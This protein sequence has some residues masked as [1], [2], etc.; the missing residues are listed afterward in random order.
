MATLI[1]MGERL[2]DLFCMESDS[3]SVVGFSIRGGLAV[4]FQVFK[5]RHQICLW[6]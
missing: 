5:E 1:C 4:N 6:H 2:V 3:E